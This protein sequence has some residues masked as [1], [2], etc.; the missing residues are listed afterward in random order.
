MSRLFLLFRRSLLPAGVAVA[1]SLGAGQATAV[2]APPECL[3][4]TERLCPDQPIA[5]DDACMLAGGVM[6]ICTG[7][8][9]AC[10]ACL[11]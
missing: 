4:G 5:C 1:L 3:P 11:F 8:G 2:S 7:V 9:N 10:C 6:G